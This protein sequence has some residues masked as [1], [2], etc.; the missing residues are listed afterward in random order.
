MRKK[1]A[2]LLMLIVGNLLLWA[3]VNEYLHAAYDYVYGCLMA[4]KDNPCYQFGD[5]NNFIFEF[6]IFMLF[7]LLAINLVAD[8]YFLWKE[9]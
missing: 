8:I 3:L 9:N 7:A 6:A 2:L 5:W 4:H 1:K